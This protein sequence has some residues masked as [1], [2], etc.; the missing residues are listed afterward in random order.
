MKRRTSTKYH[1]PLLLGVSAAVAVGAGVWLATRPDRRFDHGRRR[2]MP[3]LAG[4]RGVHVERCV[5]VMRSPEDLY[6]EWRELAHWPD[7]VPALD[8]VSPLGDKRSHWVARGPAG[9][10]VEWDAE[11]VADEPNRLITWR[12]VD[13]P[14]VDNVGSV[15]F[16]PAAG[17]R[18]TEVKVTLMYAPPAG[19]LGAAAATIFD[20]GG[21]RRV[22][23]GL[24]RFKQRMETGE[25]A[26]S[27]APGQDE[28]DGETA[29]A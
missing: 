28:V 1:G 4:G 5:T 9:M 8:S 19:R 3:A 27:R 29:G 16:A 10:P 11:L 22:R 24:R 25:V 21:E 18:G 20:A 17:G 12:S 2:A 13:Q 26:V 23:E 7:L 15:S 6:A 14:D